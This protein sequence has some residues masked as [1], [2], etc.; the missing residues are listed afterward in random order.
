MNH[1][2]P[3]WGVSIPVDNMKVTACM[4]CKN[5][6]ALTLQ[7]GPPPPPPSG[8][9]WHKNCVARLHISQTFLIAGMCEGSLLSTLAQLSCA[10]GPRGSIC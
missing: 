1:P 3:P 6:L 9:S 8:S 2:D 7:G 4:I 5:S 10:E